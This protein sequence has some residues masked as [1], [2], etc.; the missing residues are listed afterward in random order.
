[1]QKALL[2]FVGIA[3]LTLPCM[4]AQET[5]L[6]NG[7]D[8][9]GWD[10]LK[11][12]WSVKNGA[13]TGKTT[14]ANQAKQNT[15]LVWR[16]GEIAD[17]E[18]TCKF[19]MTAGDASGFCN[20]G[21]QY[22]SKLV[23]PAYFVMSGYQADMGLGPEHYTGML[24][25]E[26]GRSILARVGQKVVLHDG[27]QNTIQIIGSLGSD[28]EL[29]AGF[30]DTGWNECK[31]I[32]VGNHIQHFI[33]GRQTVDV[34]DEA[35]AG[36]K[37]GLLG[38][39][40]HKGA[41]KPMTVQFKDIKLKRLQAGQ[42]VLASTAQPAT[43]SNVSVPATIKTDADQPRIEVLKDQAPNAVE[44]ALAP[45]DQMVPGDIRQNLTFLREDLLDEGKQKPK[46]SP[47]AYALASQICNTLL[48]AL[49]E[50]NQTLAHAGFRAVE[51][52]TRTGVT[53]E[54]LEARRNY[55][56]SWPQFARENAQR[57]EL[58]S[59]ANNNAAVMAER[60]KL[61][62]TERTVALR[63]T[64]DGLYAQFREALRQSAAAK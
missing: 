61:Q 57:A 38:F 35:S 10:G 22:R 1:M 64:L 55:K 48:T 50:R 59:Q 15:F 18:F 16:G 54:A 14:K 3:A 21:I 53:S 24:Y 28:T 33:N 31:V 6:F 36:A 41:S 45:L 46:A 23:D 7:R 34:M 8:L 2:S 60:P 42:P 20:S 13:I 9:T 11:E 47:A 39:Q 37:A 26:K 52:Q 5:I 32:A 19:K 30:N 49:E 29:L 51:A 4:H 27:N 58:K 56:M 12:F 63:K 17:F 44:W 62:W 40:I 25:E 43:P